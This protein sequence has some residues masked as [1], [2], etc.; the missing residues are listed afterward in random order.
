MSSELTMLVDAQAPET[1]GVAE[2]NGKGGKICRICKEDL[3][4][5]LGSPG[6]KPVKVPALPGE[7]ADRDDA[8]LDCAQSQGL[9]IFG[10][11]SRPKKRPHGRV[12]QRMS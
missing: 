3:Y 2:V 10:A 8:H 11:D 6:G 5:R 1:N 4:G 12:R 9:Y 7:D